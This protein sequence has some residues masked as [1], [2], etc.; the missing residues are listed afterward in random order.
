MSL[1]KARI[2]SIAD[3][4]RHARTQ[5]TLAALCHLLPWFNRAL[6]IPKDK[7]THLSER[8]FFPLI[9]AL[10]D[11]RKFQSVHVDPIIAYYMTISW[12]REIIQ[13][14][15]FPTHRHKT[16]IYNKWCQMQLYPVQ[17][18]VLNTRSKEYFVSS[19][20]TC[21]T[22]HRH[23]V[24]LF[25]H[26]VPLCPWILLSHSL[27]HPYWFHSAHA[28]WPPAVFQDLCW[29]WERQ[30]GMSY[31]LRPQGLHQEAGK[32]DNKSVPI[33]NLSKC[34]IRVCYYAPGEYKWIKSVREPWHF[35]WTLKVSR[36][37]PGS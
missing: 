19:S 22:W 1:Y 30:W 24:L 4:E 11:C 25:Y 35:I 31:D 28:H 34:L 29:E 20:S 9:S 32:T 7:T 17:H 26:K 23:H 3:P 13:F 37:S 16:I 5:P 33:R 10:G 21:S 2:S 8:A 14:C 36:R 18:S 6:F 15:S 12:G 27:H